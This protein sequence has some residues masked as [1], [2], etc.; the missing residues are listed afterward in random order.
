M[1]IDLTFRYI[2]HANIKAYLE[3]QS[4]DLEIDNLIGQ[5]DLIPTFA[6]LKEGYID[7]GDTLSLNSIIDVL[8]SDLKEI[9][10]IKSSDNRDN[11]SRSHFLSVIGNYLEMLWPL[12]SQYG[13]FI[14]ILNQI[15]LSILLNN[16][17]KQGGI[18]FEEL[19]S[20]DIE[21]IEAFVY[22]KERTNISNTSTKSEKSAPLSAMTLWLL[23]NHGF[24]KE[25]PLG[26]L[27]GSLIKL[28][29]H[30]GLRNYILD[31]KRNDL[32]SLFNRDESTKSLTV[33]HAA[34]FTSLLVSFLNELMQVNT[35]IATTVRKELKP[36]CDSI[37]KPEKS[38][39]SR[40]P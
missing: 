25:M 23:Y 39:G 36:F 16:S 10:I 34:E 1:N 20:K 3:D 22:P 33:K 37:G 17:P 38:S 14:D 4:M 28:T 9:Q 11:L 31:K 15:V 18:E 35:R 26:S 29:G 6:D 5:T 2:T 24:F 7:Y 19:E 40:T 13:Y 21:I 12:K 8:N 27:K 32:K 30:A